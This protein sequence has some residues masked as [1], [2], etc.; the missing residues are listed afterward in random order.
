MVVSAPR[1][2]RYDT[3]ALRSQ[4]SATLTI[5]RTVQLS[6]VPVSDHIRRAFGVSEWVSRV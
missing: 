2:S 1:V 5:P 3:L 6:R 4:I